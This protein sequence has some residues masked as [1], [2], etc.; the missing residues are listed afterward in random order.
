MA[1]LFRS[2]YFSFSASGSTGGKISREGVCSF[3]LITSNL[4]LLTLEILGNNGKLGASSSLLQSA[5]EPLV[6]GEGLSLS[7]SL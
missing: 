3:P 4:L 6:D 5:T 1:Q 2:H 7:E